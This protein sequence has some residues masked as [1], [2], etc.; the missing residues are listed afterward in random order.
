MTYTFQS[1]NFRGKKQY[2]PFNDLL[3]N[4]IEEYSP[5]RL[6]PQRSNLLLSGATTRSDRNTASD[7]SRGFRCASASG[8]A[9]RSSGAIDPHM[10]DC[11][12]KKL[13]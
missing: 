11:Y 4:I 13:G 10:I 9:T 3:C 5:S 12:A 6:S 8:A 2:R 7:V 1:F